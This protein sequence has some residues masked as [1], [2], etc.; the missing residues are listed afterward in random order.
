MTEKTFTVFT[1]AYNR[2]DLLPR[3]YESLCKQT[4]TDFE[5]V[6]VDDGSEDGTDSL[7]A[8]WTG[9]SDF[10]IRYFHKQNGG[11]HSAL[12]RGIQEALGKYFVVADSDDW[13]L[14][15]ALAGFLEEWRAVGN[16]ENL[17]GICGLFQY[18][19]GRVVGSE[20]PKSP[21]RSN[22]ID[23]RLKYGIEGDKI[24]FTKTEILRRFPFPEE[25][26]RVY[27]PESIVWN[28]ISQVYD[29]VFVNRRFGVKEY[30][31]DG[32]TDR[33]GLNSLKN[34]LAYRLKAAE[35]V[36]GTREISLSERCRCLLTAT[37]C[38]MRAGANPFVSD[39]AP[40]HLLTLGSMPLA[41]LLNMRDQI[42]AMRVRKNNS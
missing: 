26:G 32:I 25:F 4:F 19:D 30:Q 12:N 15:D 36:N 38:S 9:Q 31:P 21:L 17:T 42:R 14:P 1:P 27:L 8:S 5:W 22:A 20:F 40:D 41:L 2:V 33:A 11:K 34:P 24:G 10:P 6:I 3:V 13:L 35:L 37:K 39:R 29:T 16:P 7:V 28:R 18:T 23:L